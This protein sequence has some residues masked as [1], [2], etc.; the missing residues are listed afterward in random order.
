MLPGAKRR[1][2]EIGMERKYYL[3]GLGLGIVVTAVIMGVALS[4]RR[5]MTDEQII[6]RAKEL[7]MV[8]NTLL[9]EE[10]AGDA[11]S[12]DAAEGENA[13]VEGAADGDAAADNTGAA[14]DAAAARDT[15]A[16]DNTAGKQTDAAGTTQE[17]DEAGGS[18]ADNTAAEEEQG[19]DTEDDSTVD[20]AAAGDNAEI[21]DDTM[22]DDAAEGQTDG[23][24]VDDAAAA[25]DASE[26]GSVV[27]TIRGGDSS[28]TV[29]K[30]LEDLG[31]VASASAYDTYLCG[32][33]Y[34]KRLRTGTFS[35]PADADEEQIA[36]IVTGGE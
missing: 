1:G 14:D 13:N 7:G 17:Q 3:R 34:D 35:I 31:V 30:K 22:A 23:S 24:T 33:G 4:G 16:E 9:S 32:H 19:R 5:S 11:E 20:D 8:E 12:G 18:T 10:A 15:A 25:G 36:R 28:Y 2:M 29:A 6:A 21:A 27:I 26:T